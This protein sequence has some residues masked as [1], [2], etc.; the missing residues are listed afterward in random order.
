MH[1]VVTLTPLAL[2]SSANDLAIMATAALLV[3]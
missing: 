2:S 1:R 3:L